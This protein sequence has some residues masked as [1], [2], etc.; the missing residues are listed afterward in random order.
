MYYKCVDK[1]F[2]T[3][4]NKSATQL[5]SFTEAKNILRFRKTASD[6]PCVRGESVLRW[7]ARRLT[8][9][10]FLANQWR[11]LNEIHTNDGW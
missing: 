6:L 4:I 11:Y 8:H 3:Q 1:R 7:R 10:T 5:D 2:D 9:T